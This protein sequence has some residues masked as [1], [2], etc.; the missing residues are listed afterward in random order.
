MRRYCDNGSAYTRANK[1]QSVFLLKERHSAKPVLFGL[2][3]PPGFWL[4]LG[5]GTRWL[6]QKGTGRLFDTQ[7]ERVLRPRDNLSD[8]HSFF[9][10]NCTVLRPVCL[11]WFVPARQYNV[12]IAQARLRY[13][14][15]KKTRR[16]RGTDW[17]Y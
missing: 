17:N 8:S 1:N 13:S 11:F 14:V 4:V 7:R 10:S 2:L 15:K 12:F 9:W 3:E 5:S 6:R 16:C